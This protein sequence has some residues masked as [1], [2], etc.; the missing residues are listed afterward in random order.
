MGCGRASQSSTCRCLTRRPN[1]GGGSAHT[2]VRM[3]EPA[4]WA[5]RHAELRPVAQ[6]TA[7]SSRQ[8]SRDLAQSAEI[9]AP[10]GAIRSLDDELRIGELSQSPRERRDRHSGAAYYP[11]L[12]VIWG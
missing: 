5:A 3:G 11:G 8:A 9:R 2:A 6:D 7:S 10:A 12:L 1:A 4:D